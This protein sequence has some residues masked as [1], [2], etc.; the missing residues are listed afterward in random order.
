MTPTVMLLSIFAVIFLILARG[1]GRTN[2]AKNAGVLF[3][4]VVVV[5]LIILTKGCPHG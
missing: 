2:S 5:L 1:D 4:I 3:V